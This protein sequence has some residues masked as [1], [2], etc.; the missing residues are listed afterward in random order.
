[1]ESKRKDESEQEEKGTHIHLTAPPQVDVKSQS[2]RKTRTNNTYLLKV[3]NLYKLYI[4]K[5][6][7][8]TSF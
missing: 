6:N 7:K 4:K 2:T 1:M 5:N 8:K 3:R